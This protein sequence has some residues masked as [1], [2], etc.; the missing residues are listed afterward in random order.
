M[1]HKGAKI[2]TSTGQFAQ[3]PVRR[4]V[5]TLLPALLALLVSV[6][7]LPAQPAAAAAEMALVP[8]ALLGE[9]GA[10]SLLLG[11]AGA[12]ILAVA[13]LL[14]TDVDIS[15]SGLVAR[16]TV[17]QVFQNPGDGWVEGIYVF[18]LPENAAVD[19][20][21]MRVGDRV[22]EGR[23][24]E[25]EE[26]R[27]IYEAA[28]QDGRKAALL[29]SERPNIFTTSIANI[30]PGEDVV[31]VIEY[32]QTLHYDQGRFSLRFPMVVGPR[33]LPGPVQIVI[34]GNDGWASGTPRVADAGRIAAPVL[35]P[36][37]GRI[38][39]VRLHVTLNAAFPLASVESQYHDVTVVESEGGRYDISLAD[40]PVPADR[41]FELVWV[42]QTGT[43]PAAALFAESVGGEDYLLLMVLPPTADA[44]LPPLRR[45]V[46]FVIDTSGSMA[47]ASIRQARDALALAVDRL[48]EGDRFNIVQFNSTTSSLFPGPREAS[49]RNRDAALRYVRRLEANG[50]T[51]MAA[52]MRR[53]LT[54]TPPRGFIRQVVFL[55]DGA[56][57]NEEELFSIVHDRLAS[58]RLFTIGIGSAP[59]SYFMR[60]AAEIGRGSFTHIGEI[61]QVA[62]RMTAL[63]GKLERPVLTDLAV[64]WPEAARADASKGVM[65]DLYE[66]EPV[67]LTAR[68]APMSG[69][70]RLSGLI[71]ETQ[72]RVELPLDGAAPGAGIGRLWARDR[73]DALMDELRRGGNPDTVRAA[74]VALGLRHRLVTKYTSFVAVDVTPTRPTDA[75]LASGKLPLNLP[76]GWV[77]GKVFGGTPPD[78]APAQ[79]DA[80]AASSPAPIQLAAAETAGV[81]IGTGRGLALPRGATPAQLHLMAGLA[82]S[83]AGLAIVFLRRR[84]PQ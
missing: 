49:R 78:A 73:I 30:G 1:N 59:N 44:P 28:R 64:T 60:K 16:T 43:G 14:G 71:G 27:R 36:D 75:P 52:A 13:P 20:L 17:S 82:L 74:V 15:V 40:G 79:R 61:E 4:L 32:Q 46:I 80:A 58:S 84:R 11:G 69:S 53:A 62:E 38:N 50:G 31:V 39:P 34:L 68:I 70:V 18:P 81:S 83:L 57:G 41:D 72:W 21:V 76:H 56:I 3:P 77:Y 7:P 26:A 29:E 55:T 54:G 33:Y 2:M 6:S 66:G 19:R 35:D 47:G 65:P 51:E 22:I 37:Q 48:G 9:V 8:R 63:F 5:L 23:I 42:P 45:E 10:G 12:D 24:R 25:R 67:I